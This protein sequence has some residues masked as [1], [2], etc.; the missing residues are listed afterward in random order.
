[1]KQWVQVLP[2]GVIVRPDG[3]PLTIT[4][5]IAAELVANGNAA[6][7][8]FKEV[9][10]PDRT[11]YTFPVLRVHTDEGTR[12]GGIEEYR[13]QDDGVYALIC[14]TPRAAELVDGE[15][16][17]H[18]SAGIADSYR[19][20]EGNVYG[21]LIEEVSITGQPVV[22]RMGRV[23]DTLHARLSRAKTLAAGGTMTVEEMAAAIKTLLEKLE[24]LE[25]RM[26]QTEEEAASY[27]EQMAK[28]SQSA[29]KEPTEP[30]LPEVGVAALEEKL[31]RSVR[32]VVS[33]ELATLRA[34][35]ARVASLNLGE[36]G[37][38]GAPASK[39]PTTPEELWQQIQ[40][41]AKLSRTERYKVFEQRKKDLGL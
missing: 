3:R 16:I 4:P 36:R 6:L 17:Q 24:S 9:S 19:D 29:P 23:Q 14:W 5:E 28:L 38:A 2:L 11:P 20:S 8:H 40:G 18:V 41:D 32:S 37:A 10:P 7:A 35:L 34:E 15:Q 33:A 31:S 25:A 30:P 26:S 39:T 13:A 12:A 21:P 22:T 1:M 27:K